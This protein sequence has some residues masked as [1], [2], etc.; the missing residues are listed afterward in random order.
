MGR[1]AFYSIHLGCTREREHPATEG[2]GG[3]TSGA[4]G[5]NWAVSKTAP[6]MEMAG[7]LQNIGK[8]NVPCHA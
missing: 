2:P 3:P 6:F 4:H 7:L 8:D 1:L 5:K